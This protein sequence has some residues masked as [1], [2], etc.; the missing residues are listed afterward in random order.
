[1]RP[2]KPRPE[3][4]KMELPGK[5]TSR[6]TQLRPHPE[7][8]RLW[9]FP[10]R[11]NVNPAG[12][13]SGKTELAKRK[14]V[15]KAMQGTR[16]DDPRFFAAAP[17]RDQAKRIYWEDL[18]RL[19][20]RWWQRK[21]P[22]ESELTIYGA[23][24]SIIQVLGMDKPERIE[25]S[26]WDGGILDEFGNMKKDSWGKNVRPALSDREGWCDL[27]GVPEGRNHY[28]DIA[29][30]AQENKSGE[31]A[32]F[33]WISAD[34]LPPS[35]IAAAKEDLDELTYQQEYE[36]SFLNFAG[37]TYYAYTEQTHNARIAYDPKQPLIFTFDFNVAPGTAGVIQEKQISDIRSG[38]VLIGE[39][40]TAIIGEVY[41]PRNSNTPMV[42]NRLIKDWG[43]HEGRVICYGD[44]TGGASKSSAVAGSDWDLVKQILRPHFGD[45]ISFDIPSVNP[46]ERDRINAVN[47]RFRTMSGKVRM[48]IDPSKAPHMVKDFEGVQCVEG[49]SGEI[50]KKKNPELSHL[51]DGIGYYA[52]KQF[53]VRKIEAGM[54]SV[55]GL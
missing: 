3:L 30:E 53:P 5:L 55:R 26:P 38:A 29:K 2:R 1:M 12:R 8:Q 37:R 18:K 27:I 39:T 20:P 33:W 19:T 7:Q 28:Y 15:K 4:P 24:G 35:E 10:A 17:T 45:R 23:N 44:A 25:G 54:V 9:L 41:I 52:H 32:Y 14:L 21:P 48:M 13:R 51:S 49:G 22:S 46:S 11:F 50:D 31:W 16:F 34:I 6:W 36:A 40:V 42:C 43:K 47:S